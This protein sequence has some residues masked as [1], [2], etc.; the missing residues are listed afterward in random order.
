MVR[1]NRVYDLPILAMAV[2][3]IY[4]MQST[5]MAHRFV[6]MTC[7]FAVPAAFLSALF[8]F[9]ACSN[10][11]KEV[12]TINVNSLVAQGKL[13]EAAN[14]ITRAL[15][16]YPNHADLLYN[17]AT[18]QRL[19]GNFDT[20][21]RTLSKVL[22]GA[23]N[24]DDANYL[25]TE[26]LIDSGKVQ[27][28]WDRFH[29]ISES[30]R[31][32]ARPQYTLGIINSLMKK[33]QNAENCFRAAIGLGDNSASVKSALAFAAC[34]QDRQE[35]GK[36]YLMEAETAPGSTPES[37]S[38]IAECHLLLEQAQKARDIAQKL[39]QQRPNDARYWSLL[40]RAEMKLLNFAD[41]EIAFTRALA[42][43]NATLW[44]QVH[45]AEMLFAANR[46]NEALAQ[47]ANAETRVAA[48]KIP[49]L[50]P[51][52][53]NLLAT[54]YAKSGQIELAKRFLN[55]SLQIDPAQTQINEILRKF[56]SNRISAQDTPP[57]ENAGSANEAT[58][59]TP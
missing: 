46:E 3:G 55:R 25:M 9:S 37:M 30:F 53:Y 18:I 59:A 15:A 33:W 28:A 48:M 45:Y 50:D 24:D 8:F 14:E 52:L 58:P 57:P 17:L 20:A 13:D 4:S 40:G 2:I 36:A 56:S 1:Y 12:R 42:C 27:E 19:Q 35:E 29:T 23:P 5:R 49:L 54:L 44:I 34:K 38:Q 51:A 10:E 22:A 43:S 26:I 7:K 6:F 41:A 11:P 16:E 47:A 21:Q 31:Q 32:K 39:T